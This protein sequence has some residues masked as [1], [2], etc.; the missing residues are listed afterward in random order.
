MFR[1]THSGS[2]WI[3]SNLTSGKNSLWRQVWSLASR[4]TRSDTFGQISEFLWAL[5]PTAVNRGYNNVSL[6]ELQ[7]E[8]C[9]IIHI[10]WIA[11]VWVLI[12]TSHFIRNSPCKVQLLFDDCKHSFFFYQ[13]ANW[14]NGKSNKFKVARWV[15]VMARNKSQASDLAISS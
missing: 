6:L 5:V 10:N 9:G 7:W 12:M 3:Q 14:D 2:Y 15:K 11:L 8:V 13:W 1:T 4:L